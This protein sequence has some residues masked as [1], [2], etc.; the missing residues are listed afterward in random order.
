MVNKL[1]TAEEAVKCVK[2][3][4]AI[5]ISGF[6]LEMTADEI[7]CTLR[8]R[9]LETESP[10]GIT[11]INS[12][13]PGE[14][15]D[16]QDRGMNALGIEGLLKRTITGFYGNAD[17]IKKLALEN[18][19][20]SYN[21]P[22]G[23]VSHLL[24]EFARGNKGNLTKIGLKT[25]ADPRL[26][27]TRVNSVSKEDYV[28]LVEVDGEEYLYYTCQKPDIAFIRA[29]TADEYGNLTFEDEA[30]LVLAQVAAMATYQ[31]HGT[32]IVQV[33]N[34]VSAGSLPAQ[35]VHIPG[36]Y[37][38]RVVVCS[39][40]AKY[41]RQTSGVIYDP[42]YSGHYLRSGLAAQALPLDERKIIGRRAAMELTPEAVVNLGI[43]M[44]ETVSSVAAEEGIAD[45]LVLTIETGGIG[46][47]P[48]SGKDFGASSNNWSMVG[49]DKIFDL[50]DG[51]GLDICFLGGAQI[52]HEGNVNS[53]KFAGRGGMMGCGGFINI[54]QPTKTIVFCLT[55]TSGGLQV[56]VKDGKLTIVKEGKIRKFLKKIEQVTFSGEY[57]NDTNQSVLFVTERAVFKLTKAGLE[58]IEI[59]PGVDLDKDIL[60]QMEFAPIV[61]K[62]LKPMNAKIFYSE[63]AGIKE[64]VL[65][66]E[67]GNKC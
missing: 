61:S 24:R 41:H 20:E 9:Y 46:G 22:L 64:I 29:T 59:A 12:A 51:G 16:G 18:K 67:K 28:K 32:V 8:K 21:F 19:I 15:A 36:I 30:T 62:E 33:K 40:V 52:D 10:K 34:Y 31:N 50:Y 60:E 5:V 54:S 35:A 2:D 42:V 26:E 23:V 55:F 3:G 11:I 27:G 39:D 49:E 45:K 63:K 65:A 13:C 37:V 1:F 48:A 47:V 14:F 7:C 6:I 58:L 17:R 25:F 4:D 44:P 43:G 56:E 66:K 38:D 57:A 53:S